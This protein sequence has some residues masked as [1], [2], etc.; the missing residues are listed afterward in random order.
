MQE[1]RH[2]GGQA[3]RRVGIEEGRHTGGQVYGGCLKS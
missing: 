2:R 1:G 3:Q